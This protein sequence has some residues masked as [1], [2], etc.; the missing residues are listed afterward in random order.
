M[1]ANRTIINGFVNNFM[2][3]N[4]DYKVEISLDNLSNIN[5]PTTVYTNMIG[6][7][8]QSSSSGWIQNGMIF[9]D[10]D[11]KLKYKNRSGVISILSN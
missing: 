1:I 2:I 10:T 7:L 3:A 6:I 9:E 4:S 11:G 8:K 5:I